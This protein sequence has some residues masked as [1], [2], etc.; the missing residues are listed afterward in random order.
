MALFDHVALFT[1]ARYNPARKTLSAKVKRLAAKECFVPERWK[2]ES[3]RGK[4][5]VQVPDY[6]DQAALTA[7]EKQLAT[8]SAAGFCG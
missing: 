2:P 3:W 7:V 1:K 8:L 5:V 4:P 6:P